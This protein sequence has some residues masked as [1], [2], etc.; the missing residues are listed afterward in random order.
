VA[1]ERAKTVR[2][3]FRR[4]VELGSSTLLVQELPLDGVTSK[5][6]TMQDARVR[7]GKPI[8]TSLTKVNQ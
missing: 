6:W 4:F 8:V 1:N 2:H 3:P 7:E 5:A